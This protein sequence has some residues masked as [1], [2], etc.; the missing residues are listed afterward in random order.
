MD[1]WVLFGFILGY[2]TH[3]SLCFCDRILDKYWE[4]R[5]REENIKDY[6]HDK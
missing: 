3:L 2:I 6:E 1:K 5:D 4:K